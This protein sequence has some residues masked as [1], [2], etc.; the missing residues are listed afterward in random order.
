MEGYITLGMPV[1]ANKVLLQIHAEMES[2]KNKPP[3]PE[4]DEGLAPE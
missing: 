1:E 4:T 3:C 2:G